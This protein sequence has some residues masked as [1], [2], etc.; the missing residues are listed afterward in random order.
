MNKSQKMIKT[1][2]QELQK[3]AQ[4]IELL[5]QEEH[6]IIRQTLNKLDKAEEALEASRIKV[7][8]KIMD[9]EVIIKDLLKKLAECQLHYAGLHS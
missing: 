9:L 4:L 7:G 8:V 2:L 5:R 6:E 3:T 1:T